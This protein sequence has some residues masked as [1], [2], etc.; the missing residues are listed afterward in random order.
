MLALKAKM[1]NKRTK[2]GM[3][4]LVVVALIEAGFAAI[5]YF[6]PKK[7][8][9]EVEP[10]KEL[11]DRISPLTT[12]AVFFQISTH[13]VPRSA[14][15]TRFFPLSTVHIISEVCNTECAIHATGCYQFWF[16]DRSICPLTIYF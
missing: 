7:E 2:A 16:H 5:I 15:S 4:I 11:D 10:I 14:T 3:A 9:P 8:A 12:Q 6:E 1:M 13:L